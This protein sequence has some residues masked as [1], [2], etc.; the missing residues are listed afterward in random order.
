MDP[1]RWQRIND[2]F[3]D[4]LEVRPEER[5]A[6]LESACGGDS[7]L[8]ENVEALLESDAD[9]AGQ[10]FLEPVAMNV[11]SQLPETAP[12]DPRIGQRIGAYEIK[13]VIG[14]GGM[15]N[16]YLAVRTEDF[17][18][19]AAVKIL[20]RGMDTDEILRRFRTEIR[21]Q[22]ALS[23]H[24]HIAGLLD[25]GTTDDGLPYFIMDYVEGERIDR[26]C[27]RHRLTIDER[28]SLFRLVCAAVQFAHQHAVIHRDLKPSNILVTPDGTPKLIDFG[29]AKLANP[30]L[31]SETATPTRT[32]LRFFTPDYASPEQIRGESITTA[33]DIYSLGI[34]LYELLSGHRP[35][36]VSG[37]ST[38]EISRAITDDEPTRPSR[39]IIKTVPVG[40]DGADERSQ[41]P[42]RIGKDRGTE[43]SRL[44]RR[45]AGDLDTIVLMALR[46][47]PQRRYASV[48]QF[49]ADLQRHL[50]GLPVTARPIGTGERVWRWCQRNPVQASLI[51]AILLSALFG[52][53]HLTRLSEQLVRSTAVESAAQ[54]ADML[55]AVQD[56]YSSAIVQ[57]VS[58]DVHATHLYREELGAIPVPATFTIDLCRYLHEQSL[59]GT[60]AKLY[61]DHPWR[62]D[63]SPLDDF[64]RTALQS[65]TTHPE[66][67]FFRFTEYRDRA[68]LRYATARVMQQSCV[69]CH[70]THPDS[71]KK[72][73]QLGD[74][75]GVLEVIRPLDNDIARTRTGLRGTF[76][77]MGGM[78]IGLLLISTLVLFLRRAS[79][80]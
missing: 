24:P 35:Y 12:R 42:E 28:I 5:R 57:R 32:E 34:V 31:S 54:H 6:W 1:A 52:L 33:S 58:G 65:L 14:G 75:R 40:Q 39:A 10:E 21:V 4:A 46:K 13:R 78:S 73:W 50:D 44:Q 69:D 26:Y 71:P 76:L 59:T 68:V 20:K 7:N 67:P 16:V 56:F 8:R 37:D 77:T 18:Q 23:E 9:D 80:R 64:Q 74:V 53:W 70:N 25:A 2:L 11:K 19:R 45:M 79:V 29:I 38:F 61:S 48:E 72:D 17:K 60:A 49:S 15:G 27:D 47:E 62:P 3:H 22:A 36:N 66:E 43:V 41:T 55:Q 30:E 51:P 63:V